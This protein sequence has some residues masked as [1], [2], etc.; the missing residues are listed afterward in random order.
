MSV[1]ACVF[2]EA[3]N[4]VKIYLGVYLC[5]CTVCVYVPYQILFS[6]AVTFGFVCTKQPLG[7][8]YFSVVFPDVLRTGFHVQ[9]RP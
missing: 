4:F 7:C 6:K 1:Y 2:L 9:S 5:I 8:E 3:N